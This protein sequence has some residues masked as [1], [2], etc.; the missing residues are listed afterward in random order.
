MSKND[1]TENLRKELNTMAN[2]LEEVLSS[3][4]KPKVKLKKIRS[5]AEN[6]LK[7]TR[8]Q[9]S[10]TGEKMMDKTKELK[11]KADTYVHDN[12]WTGVAIGVAAGLVLGI[13]LSRR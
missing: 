11:D 1:T 2:T 7:S 6:I 12:P 10:E 4:D 8:D 3:S 5:K 9:L 13:L